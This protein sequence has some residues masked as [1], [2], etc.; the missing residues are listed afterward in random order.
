MYNTGEL[1]APLV[2]LQCIQFDMDFYQELVDANGR[3]FTNKQRPAPPSA[4]KRRRIANDPMVEDDD[5]EEDVPMA[6]VDDKAE[7]DQLP[8]PLE[9]TTPAAPSSEDALAQNSG[10]SASTEAP[11]AVGPPTPVS[12]A[13]ANIVLPPSSPIRHGGLI[14]LRIPGGRSPRS[15]TDSKDTE[16]EG[17][18]EDGLSS[19]FSSPLPSL[20]PPPYD[21]DDDLYAD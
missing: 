5:K 17:E 10:R 11:H 19:M 14:R 9:S 13:G 21:S 3:Y 2:R 20:S 15:C 16:E 1:R 4:A 6:L 7:D 12:L 18:V 8:S